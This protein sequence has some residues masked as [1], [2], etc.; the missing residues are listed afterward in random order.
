IFPCTLPGKLAPRQ[1]AFPEQISG[2]WAWQQALSWHAE[3]GNTCTAA[4]RSYIQSED[5]SG[6]KASQRGDVLGARPVPPSIRGSKS[7]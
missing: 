4:R 3:F 1:R 5:S 6:D 2:W 7:I